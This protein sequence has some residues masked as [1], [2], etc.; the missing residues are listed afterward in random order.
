MKKI[1]IGILGPS[2][3]AIR[4]T[5]VAIKNCDIFEYIGVAVATKEERT[6]VINENNKANLDID[7]QRG[8]LKAQEI[9]KHFDGKVYIGYENFLNSNEIEAVYIALPPSL[10]YF[11]AKKALQN[12]LHVFLEKPFTTNLSQTINL[13]DYAEE[14]R[15]ALAENYAFIFH[16]QISKIKELINSN[17]IGSVQFIKTN[18]GFPLISFEN[19][20]YKKVYGGGALLDCGGYTIK[21][22]QIFMKEMRIKN[23]ML[24][25]QENS[26][27][28]IY[29]AITAVD[30][31][32]IVAQLCF[33]MNQEY[34]CELEIIGS[35]GCIKAERIYTAPANCA[36]NVNIVN[37]NKL[38]TVKIDP[39]DQFKA[40]LF[41]FAKMIRYN[42]CRI[43]SYNSILKQSKYIETCGVVINE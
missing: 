36:T 10:H 4:K 3:I 1:K 14:N 40:S 41:E 42:E 29:G 11:W 31:Q 23:S 39:F 22:A 17:R 8:L 13:I 20:R 24:F 27:V 2:D 30:N 43:D 6:F 5:I 15:L 38:E 12:G 33:S 25:K 35:K 37:Q 9:K 32:N 19:F 7:F 16:P 34:K 28:D 18:F 26:D 21:L